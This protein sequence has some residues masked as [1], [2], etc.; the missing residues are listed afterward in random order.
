[1]SICCA[2]GGATEVIGKS[3]MNHRTDQVVRRRACTVCGERV[4]TIELAVHNVRRG[5]GHGAFVALKAQLT[6]RPE[7]V[8]RVAPPQRR[9]A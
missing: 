3:S 1:M 7:P 2:C 8:H 4:T 6:R 9:P 5:Q